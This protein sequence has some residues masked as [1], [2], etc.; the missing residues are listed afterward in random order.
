MASENRTA[1]RGSNTPAPNEGFKKALAGAVRAVSGEK[2]L[3]VSYAPDRP[4]LQPG[5]VRLPEPPRAMTAEDA[6]ITRGHADAFAL[7]VACHDA[8]LHATLTPQGQVARAAYDMIEQARVEAIGC[9][10]MS[11]MSRNLS[12]MVE[13]RHTKRGSAK[14]SNREDSPIEE[15]LT[16]VV[17][18]KLT[19]LEP[20]ECARRMVDAWR[21]LIEERA[22]EALEQLT[23]SLESQDAFAR[24]TRDV[25]AALDMADAL[26]D[27]PE[28]E[29]DNDN[30]D[31]DESDPGDDAENNENDETSTGMTPRESEESDS[32]QDEGEFEESD[33]APDEMAEETE[34]S[35]A[36]EADQPYRPETGLSNNPPENDYK[37]FEQRFDE[38]VGAEELCDAEELE[39][40]RALLD[41]QIQH[42]QQVV[43]K[44]ANRLQRR[45]LAQQ[46]RGW[47]FDLEE[48]LLDTARIT[49]VVT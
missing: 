29:D 4:G 47:D 35:E 39:R 42:M 11:G 27:E 38:T 32:Q 5:K 45:L 43:T 46:N 18:E 6:A 34:Q 14:S 28:P 8:T 10:R 16:L 2:E 13:D 44:L 23:D 26:Q 33:A 22:G 37:V 48:G 9:K 19:G 12:A 21:P 24:L 7:R 3:G 17:R 31:E 15:A 40:L 41:R 25:L 36:S 30:D 20:P 1:K 49:R